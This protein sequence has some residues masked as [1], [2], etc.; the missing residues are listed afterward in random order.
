LSN[1]QNRQVNIR[2]KNIWSKKIYNIS[3][4]IKKEWI[5]NNKDLIKK[6]MRCSNYKKNKLKF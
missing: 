4:N 5:I 2:Y 3:T 6:E 1:N